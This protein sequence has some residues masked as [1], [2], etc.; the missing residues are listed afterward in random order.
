MAKILD[1][2]DATKQFGGLMANEGITFDVEQGEIVGVVGPNGAGKTTLF[3]SISGAHSLTRGSIT[4]DG[5]DITKLKAHEICR[6][7]I[8]RTF[9][10]P[11]SINDMFVWENVLVGA[12]LRIP[13]V[14]KAMEIVDKELNFCNLNNY[15]NMY[16]GKLNV[17]Q[18]KRLEI[19][20]AL[21]TQPKLLLLDETMAGLTA[22]ERKDA[23]DLIRKVNS[24]GVAILTIE[25][26]M[27]VVMSVSNRV[28][29]LVS[30]KLLMIGKPEEVTSNP[31]VIDAYLGGGNEN[32][33]G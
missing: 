14:S 31:E 32:D 25:H 7:G 16:A 8:G 4:F 19:A 33:K 27:D 28:V 21:A 15:R 26:N 11:Q 1:V 5:D 20:R 2:V 9:Q 10:I 24:R 29:V 3:N 23:V 30:G 13:N 18:K 12:L 6:L 22:T 17:A